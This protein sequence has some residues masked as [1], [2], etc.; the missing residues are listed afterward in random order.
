[1]AGTKNNLGLDY[2]IDKEQ[3]PDES[4]DNEA[5]T[6]LSA[7]STALLGVIH[8]IDDDDVFRLDFKLDWILGEQTPRIVRRTFALKQIGTTHELKFCIIILNMS[9]RQPHSPIQNSH[10]WENVLR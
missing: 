7:H 10:I 2:K 6:A 1:M 3:P 9:Y 8:D 4:G 5:E